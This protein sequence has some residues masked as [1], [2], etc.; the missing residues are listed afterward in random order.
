MDASK[1]VLHQAA[2][3]AYRVVGGKVEVLL[4]TSRETGRWIIPKGNI[5][6]GSTP[7]QAA[8]REALE[9]AGVKGTI[10]SSIPLGLYKYFKRLGS[11]ETRGATVE[12]YLL[13]ARELLS[14][15]PEKG[16]RKLAWVSTAE[17]VR[18][19]EE[20]GV[21]PLLRRLMEVEADLVRPR[22]R[23]HRQTSV[24]AA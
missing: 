24:R 2:A 19:I 12:V 7:A 10:E 21:E 16:Q 22:R 11:G 13:R 9:E 8:K 5:A 14:K 20:P 17:A 15:W 6:T 4:V 3:L 1:A 23:A 18:I